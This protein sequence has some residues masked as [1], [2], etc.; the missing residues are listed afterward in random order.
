[1]N[2]LKLFLALKPKKKLNASY[3]LSLLISV[4]LALVLGG[5]IMLIT[6]YNDYMSMK[7]GR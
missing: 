7:R 2:T 6:G 5:L 1:M 3:L 4:V